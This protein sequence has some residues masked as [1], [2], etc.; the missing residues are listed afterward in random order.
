MITNVSI[1]PDW[2]WY[3]CKSTGCQH[4]THHPT[5]SHS[6]SV[7]LL[8]RFSPQFLEPVSKSIL[9]LQTTERFSTSHKRKWTCVGSQSVSFSAPVRVNEQEEGKEKRRESRDICGRPER[10]RCGSEHSFGGKKQKER[11][12]SN[13]RRIYSNGYLKRVEA[14]CVLESK[15]IIM[16]LNENENLLLW[17]VWQ[18]LNE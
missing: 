6:A 1:F 2:N 3:Q 7:Y 8:A 15:P 11:K 9:N 5:F 12:G 14:W 10:S 4:K 16:E 18:V 13:N 17:Q